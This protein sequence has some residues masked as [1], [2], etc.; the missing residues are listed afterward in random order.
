M[1]WVFQVG[2]VPALMIGLGGCAKIQARDLIR[3]GNKAYEDNLFPEA[4]EAY[5]QSL[6]FEPDGV[7]VLWNRACAAEAE[8]LRLASEGT[9]EAA[10]EARHKYADMALAD[11]KAWATKA[12]LGDDAAGEFEQVEKHRLAILDADERC[13]DLLDHW[14]SKHKAEPQEP[15]WFFVVARQHD[16]CGQVDKARDWLMK[17]TETFPDNSMVWMQLANWDAQNIWPT[18]P[19]VPYNADLSASERIKIA[20]NVITY[21]DKAIAADPKARGAYEI[22]GLMFYQRGLAWEAPEDPLLIETPFERL[23]YLRMREDMVLYAREQAEICKI[24]EK[25]FCPEESVNPETCCM[26]AQF[27]EEELAA[28]AEA[29]EQTLAEIAE[30]EAE[31]VKANKNRRDDGFTI[32]DLGS[33]DAEDGGQ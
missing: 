12:S 24:D 7:T 20:N 33:V 23:A 14:L 17:A 31:E 10:I 15:R 27:T 29:M 8:V 5:T 16:H 4:I 30:I 19:T 18:D 1:H 3:E 26:A 28:D 9:D 22:R 11:F 6:E 32:T 13:E 2:I 25:P 21:A